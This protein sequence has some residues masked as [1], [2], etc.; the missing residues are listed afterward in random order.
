MQINDLMLFVR[1]ADCGSITAAA[2]ELELS[3]AAA[4]AALKRLEKQLDTSLFIRSTRRLR[5]TDTGERYLIYC[6]RALADLSLGQQAI[7]DVKE[8]ISGVVSL[9]VPSD[10]GRSVLLP[11]LDDFMDEYPQLKFRLHIGD[12]LS[13]FYHDKIDVALR[14]GTPKDSSLVAFQIAKVKRLLCASPEYIA[15]HGAIT[16]IEQLSDHNCLFFM[17]DERTHDQWRFTKNG[18][19]FKV[20]VTGNRTC[21]DAEVARRWAV[22]GKGL[23][24]KS[25]LDLGEDILRGRLVPMLKDFEG[26]SADLYLVCPGREHVT[27]VILLLRDMLRA[28]C[29]QRL[30]TRG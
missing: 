9:A 18:R 8:K 10:T 16:S 12:T 15:K 6:R 24:Y 11:W 20:R 2:T 17:L 26:E 3:P 30:D 7:D 29:K 5:L 1:V 23:V 27:P 22:A 21:N 19:E 14:I 13:D 28:R 25:A 4:S